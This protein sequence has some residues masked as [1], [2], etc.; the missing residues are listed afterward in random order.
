MDL[1]MERSN[2]RLQ[3]GEADYW[4]LKRNV[5]GTYARRL[6]EMVELHFQESPAPLVLDL[7]QVPVVDSEGAYYLETARRRH[8][9][10]QIVG[11]PRDYATLPRSIQETLSILRP[12]DSLERALSSPGRSG[13][14]GSWPRRRRHTR[15]PVR[16]PVEIFLGGK[17][18]VATMHD[19]SLGGGRL[20]R[21]ASRILKKVEGAPSFPALTIA[22]IDRDPLGLEIIKSRNDSEV[23]TRP[24]YLLPGNSGMGVRFA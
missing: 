8:A 7:R 16:I 23:V 18:A 11:T 15:I 5:A 24:V 10:L 22:G 9:D 2:G 4:I 14:R 19:I 17:S 13:P 12:S 21:V 3:Y 1:G 20:G 6:M